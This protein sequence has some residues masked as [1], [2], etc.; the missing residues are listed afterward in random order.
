MTTLNYATYDDDT[1]S[2]VCPTCRAA[3]TAQCLVK[4]PTGGME[5]ISQPHP[6]RV[7]L[8]H[9]FIWHCAA[10]DITTTRDHIVQELIPE[11][12]IGTCK[13]V[14]SAQLPPTSTAIVQWPVSE[15]DTDI[16]FEQAPDVDVGSVLLIDAEY[17]T[18]NDISNADN[19]GVDR[20]THGTTAAAHEAGAIASIW[21][22][23]E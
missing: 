7:D 4:K 19:I 8:A 20:G 13:P 23:Q 18:V 10:C 14:E 15:T 5:F 16:A 11:E 22:P 3:A 1:L 6:A 2:V 9:G 17:M 12:R 21:S